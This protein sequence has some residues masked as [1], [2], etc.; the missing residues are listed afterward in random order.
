MGVL[1]RGEVPTNHDGKRTASRGASERPHNGSDAGSGRDASPSGEWEVLESPSEK[2]GGTSAEGSPD[3]VG[4][5]G[6]GELA[7]EEGE[8]ELDGWEEARREA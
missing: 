5:P 7:G 6:G 2:T 3:P 4:D 1:S 8:E